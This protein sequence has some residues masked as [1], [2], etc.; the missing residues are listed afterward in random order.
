MCIITGTDKDDHFVITRKPDG[1]TNVSIYRIKDGKK[2]DKF[3]DVD[4]D[5]DVTS[6]M[7]IYGLDDEDIFEVDGKSNKY[8]KIKII[9]GQ[10]NDTYRD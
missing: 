9:G 1:I 6:E 2:A 8:I 4:Y 3:W 5:K 10:N 7:W